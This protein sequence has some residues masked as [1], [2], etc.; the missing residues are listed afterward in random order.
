MSQMTSKLSVISSFSFSKVKQELK[1]K[2][3]TIQMSDH[4]ATLYAPIFYELFHL[5]KIQKEIYF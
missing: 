1:N 3:K 4:T 2:C 5:Q